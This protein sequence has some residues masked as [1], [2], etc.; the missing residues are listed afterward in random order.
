VRIE[1]VTFGDLGAVA[2]QEKQVS[3]L[4]FKRH[5]VEF[6]HLPLANEHD[7]EHCNREHKEEL[8]GNN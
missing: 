3:K 6:I 4:V 2:E 1:P 8:S 7:E 5:E